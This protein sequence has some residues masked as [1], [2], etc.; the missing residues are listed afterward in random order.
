MGPV[1]QQSMLTIGSQIPS[2]ISP[3][4]LTGKNTT[5]P[6]LP[7]MPNTRKNIMQFESPIGTKQQIDIL[8]Y[9]GGSEDIDVQLHR[10]RMREENSSA[11]ASLEEQSQHFLS[12]RPGSQDCRD[13]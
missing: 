13:Q 8:S 1:K 7:A 11:C 6:A 4:L 3:A 9:E 2:V 10:K 5:I 12:A